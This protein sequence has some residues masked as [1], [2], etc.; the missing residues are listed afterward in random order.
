MDLVAGAVG[1][2][3]GKLCE[4]LH[5]EYKLQKGLPEQ[6]ESLKHELESA[7]TAL[8]KVGEV[9]PEQLDPQVRLWAR[10][11]REASYDMEDI[12]DTCL[13]EVADPAEKKDGLL[14]RLHK[15]IADLLKKSK[16][17]HTIAGA[18]KDMKKRLQ[19]VDE[20]RDRFSVAVSQPAL[21]TKP[22]PRLADMHKE[23]AQLIGIDNARAELIAM[24]QPDLKNRKRKRKAML[25]P[26]SHGNADSDVSGRS[27]NS[28]K[29]KIVS[30]V[31]VGG[32]GKTTLAKAVYDELGPR[33][34]C[35]AFLS[36]GRKPDLAQVFKEIFLLL[37][38]KEYKAIRDVKNESLLI[39]ELRKFLQN[40]RY[41]IIIDDVWD[42]PTWMTI[43][44]AFVE[45]DSGSRVITT[46]RNRDVASREEVYEL[47][48]LSPDH[49]EKLFKTRLFGVNGE[50][51]ANHPAAASEKIL[52]KCGG[53][54]LAIITMAS[55][56]V[57]K[58]REDWFDLCNSPGFYRGNGNQQ[59][60]DTEWILSLSYYDLPSYLRT[61]LL[62]LSVYPEDYVIEKDSLIWKWIAE[63]FVEKRRG[64]SLF[65][66]G[67]EYFNQLINRSMIQA[68]ESGYTG[69]VGGCRVHD[70]VLDLI[71]DLSYKENFVT[72]SNDDEGTSPHQNKVR[73]L[74]HQNRIMKQTQQDDH[75]DMAQV[76][77]FVA[78]RC[79]IDSHWVLHPSFKLMRVLDLEGCRVPWEG[80]QGLKDLGN[81]LHLRYLGL[82]N[83]FCGSYYELPEEIG[84]LKFLQ[85]LDLQDSGIGVLPSGV[86]QLTQLVCLSGDFDTC[87]PNGS[88]LRK[89]TSLEYL[90]IR[91]DNL[92][93]ESQRQFMK[94]V[95]NQSEV[96]VLDIIG[97][98]KGMVQSD[99][100]KSLGNL[101]KLHKLHIS[102]IWDRGSEVRVLDI[103]GM[104]KGM[105]QSDLVQSLGNLHKLQHLRGVDDNGNGE[106]AMRKWDRVVLPRHLRHLGLGFI[107]FR[108]L[109][110][111]ISP[112][113]LPILRYL[114]LRVE[115]MDESSL[116]N[117][118][119]LPE[120]RYLGLST[121][122]PSMACTAT[123]ANITAVDGFFKKLRFCFLYGWMVQLVLNEDSTGVS[124]SIWNGMGV[125][126]FGSKTKDEYSR[127]I[128]PP[129]VMPN[130]QELWFDVPVRALYKDGNGSCGD[131]RLECLPSLRSV[132][133]AV[134]CEGAS[135]DDVEKAEAELRH[136]A[137]LHPNRPRI[138]LHHNERRKQST[139]QDDKEEGGASVAGN[140]VVVTE[141]GGDNPATPS[142]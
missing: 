21:P 31:G 34:D 139:D 23:A 104:L 86:C 2:V 65:Q 56:L 28:R 102:G 132:Q 24:L 50:Y 22:D 47:R 5:E 111:W 122:R 114:W 121:A 78:C 61:C 46:T 69:I 49:S 95:G 39:G 89:V 92:D 94:D 118:G 134:D 141:S 27:S 71:R 53:I 81:L 68:V 107:S 84:K 131:L 6:I 77:S 8:S 100:V 128:A 40:K 117:L 43:K 33:Y 58:S 57:G 73:R 90:R 48:T 129:P 70:M 20:R 83:T 4:L 9:P 109:P 115:H 38:K 74:A 7:Q 36:V 99:L 16:A 140:E 108:Q 98:L 138:E 103:I 55:L 17:R 29:M 44:S 1:N 42:I 124:F 87:T 12:L 85:T 119:G 133:I 125:I 93:E 79:N 25:L 116:R 3:I 110:A 82:R 60:D 18:I 135:A 59:V 142:C 72:I 76:R 14:K 88:F 62:Y 66:R 97:T 75:M 63:G 52:K 120:L 41:F 91:I 126:A 80:W 11:V 32:L 30:V 15:N 113:H 136:T 106:A 137:N 54:P 35:G 45:N 127:S 67:E 123:L 26:A 19:A 112:A 37:D 64:T 101:H 13:I 96:R 130:L 105:V 51:P 10:E